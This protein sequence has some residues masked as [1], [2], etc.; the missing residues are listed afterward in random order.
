MSVNVTD[1]CMTLPNNVVRCTAD[2][3]HIQGGNVIEVC[4][5]D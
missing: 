2:D 5:N 4:D 3:V 1:D